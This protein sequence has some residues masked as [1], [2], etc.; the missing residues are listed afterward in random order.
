MAP[1]IMVVSETATGKIT[2]SDPITVSETSSRMRRNPRIITA[3]D[4]E[5]TLRTIRTT[6]DSE[7]IQDQQT[8]RLLPN[9]TTIGIPTEAALDKTIINKETDS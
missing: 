5:I 7:I 3:E 8:S 1:P 6:E 4:L 2:A 9:R